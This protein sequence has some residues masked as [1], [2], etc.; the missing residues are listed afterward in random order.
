[1]GLI[2]AEDLKYVKGL[3]LFILAMATL[4][5][6]F[7]LLGVQGQARLLVTGQAALL[8]ALLLL[9][10]GR[11]KEL[12][13]QETEKFRLRLLPVFI[14]AGLALSFGLKWLQAA[15]LQSGLVVLPGACQVIV[16]VSSTSGTEALL[17]GLGVVILGPVLEE[18]LFRLI[19]LGLVYRALYSSGLT[20][21]RLV[22]LIWVAVVAAVFA[23]LHGPDQLSFPV[24][25]GL[26]LIYSLVFLKYGLPASVLV[27]G[28]F[29]A[30][31]YISP[32]WL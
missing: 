8:G 1:M 14:A 27:H 25:F 31:V 13:R 24:Y 30:G 29:N 7:W 6:F 9:G 23:M 20:G 18:I 11:L 32:P 10:L 26:S 22:F 2:A 4:N 21:F 3:A 5:L 19:G 15:A 12:Y 28:S 16:P 17:T